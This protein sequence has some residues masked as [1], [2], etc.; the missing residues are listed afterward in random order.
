[1]R[2]GLEVKENVKAWEWE[3]ADQRETKSSMTEQR[4]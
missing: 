3:V 2:K 4:G 1:M